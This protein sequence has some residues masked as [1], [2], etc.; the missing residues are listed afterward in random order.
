MP[1]SKKIAALVIGD[2]SSTMGKRIIV[3]QHHSGNLQ[4]I[5]RTHP[6]YMTLQYPLLFPYGDIRFYEG[7][8]YTNYLSSKGE[9]FFVNERVIHVSYSNTIL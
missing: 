5:W 3:L 7:I 2:F 8:K 9:K 4:R 1:S 6:L